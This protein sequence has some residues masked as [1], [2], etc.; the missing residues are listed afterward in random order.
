MEK[1]ICSK[2]H[3]INYLNAELNALYHHASLKLGLTDS[4]A[5]VLYTIYDN[6]ENCLLSDIYK[7]SGVSKQT[8]NSA[9]RKLEKERIIYLEQHSGRT[10]KVVLTDTGKEYVQKTVARLFDAEAAAFASWTEEEI[11]AHIGFMEKYIDSFREQIE[12]L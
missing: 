7:Q 3:R 12:K 5:M 8:V 10:K 6:G 9:I 4:A 11:N 2:I 1:R